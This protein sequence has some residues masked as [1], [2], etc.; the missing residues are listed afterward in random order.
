MPKLLDNDLCEIAINNGF[1]F[2]AIRPQKL[3][4][5]EYTLVTIAVDKTGSVSGFEND[6]LNVVKQSLLS[7][8]KSARSENLLIRYITF[9]H[10]VYEEHGFIGL[11]N[12][13]IDALKAPVCS[14]GTALYDALYSAI[15][16][17]N[18][19]AKTLNDYDFICNGICFIIT[20]GDDNESRTNPFMIKQL[21]EE[22]KKQ[23]CLDSLVTVLI[24][25]NSSRFK[26]KLEQVKVEAQLTSYIDA[27]D[28][29]EDNLARLAQ[30]VSRSISSQ[31]INVGSGNVLDNLTI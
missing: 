13:D 22:N 16:A 20:D 14:G 3:G 15:S 10:Q 1:N 30:F 8:K 26:N 6:L 2:S 29:N 24:G 31:S 18:T 4:A 23:E 28:V 27:G 7:C 5:T 11:E 21:I 19:Y 12:I 17:T 25:I 9:N